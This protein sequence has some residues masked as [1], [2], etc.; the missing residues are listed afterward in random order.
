MT[1]TF[2]NL[3]A[4]VPDY[5]VPG[6]MFR[7][8]TPALADRQAFSEI[9]D[10]ISENFIKRGVTKVMGA[11]SRGFILGAPVSLRLNAGF[12]PAR[13]PGKLPR[14]GYSCYYDLE[15]GRDG[16][17]LP[18]GALEADDVVLIIDDLLATGGTAA[19]MGTMVKE[20]GAQIAGYAFFAE[21]KDLPGREKIAEVTDAEIFSLV[22]L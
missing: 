4:T 6:V 9:I 20:A 7:D 16:L 10:H 12:I 21:L 17:E 18:E 8:F 1:T 5:P 2:E 14:V 3:I 22:E 15:Y 13:K 19:A 11:E